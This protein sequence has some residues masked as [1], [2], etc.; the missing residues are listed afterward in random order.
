MVVHA[1][2]PSL[3]PLAAVRATAATAA[4]QGARPWLSRQRSAGCEVRG[5]RPAAL[6]GVA[7]TT[8][9]PPEG[10]DLDTSI[11]SVADVRAELIRMTEE[12]G[13]CST[14]RAPQGSAALLVS[15][16]ER[17]MPRNPYHNFQHIYDV[18]QFLFTL[19]GRSGLVRPNAGTEASAAFLGPLEI[20]AL[21]AGCLCHDLDHP[22]HS[23]V[24]EVA[25][26]GP[27][28]T[29]HTGAS[30]APDTFTLE[31]HHGLVAQRLLCEELGL[32][33]GLEPA[34]AHRFQKLV[35][36]VIEA[37]DL[38]RHQQLYTSF[39]GIATSTP[40]GGSQE[41]QVQLM[42][43][44]MKC[45]DLANTVRPPSCRICWENNAFEE[46]H[47]EGDALV[48]NGLRGLDELPAM[49]D[50]REGKREEASEVFFRSLV[51]PTFTLLEE[52]LRSA[53]GLKPDMATECTVMLRARLALAVQDKEGLAHQRPRPR[54]S[55]LLRAA[56]LLLV[57]LL[58]VL[59]WSPLTMVVPG[60]HGGG[61][62]AGD[63]PAIMFVN[64]T[65]MPPIWSIICF[66]L[67]GFPLI[68][69]WEVH[70][71]AVVKAQPT[72]SEMPAKQNGTLACLSDGVVLV[73]F[74]SGSMDPGIDMTRRRSI[75]C[76]DDAFVDMGVGSGRLSRAFVGKKRRTRRLS[77]PEE[78]MT[79]E[80]WADFSR[81][82]AADRPVF[83]SER[84]STKSSQVGYNAED[85]DDVEDSESLEQVEEQ[86]PCWQGVPSPVRKHLPVLVLCGTMVALSVLNKVL[87][88]LV[89]CSVGRYVHALSS[90]TN[91]AYLFYAWSTVVGKAWLG[92]DTQRGQL[93]R[94][95]RFSAE[96]WRLF[97]SMGICESVAFTLMP[98]GTRG[99]PK[100]LVPVIAQSTL[101]MS[102]VLNALFFRK[103]YSTMQMLGV[104]LIVTGIVL[105]T[106]AD[107]AMATDKVS[108]PLANLVCPLCV[109]TLSYFFLVVSLILKD[110]T[111]LVSA[112]E[113]EQMD[114]FL[115][116]GL[117]GVG[118]ALALL[119]QWPMNFAVLTELSVG[120]YFQAAID[121]FTDS[122]GLMPMLIFLYWAGNILYRLATLTAMRQLSSL[123]TLL[124][125]VL[126]VPLSSLV[127]CLPLGL[128]LIGPPDQLSLL[129]VFGTLVVCFG[130]LTF[131]SN[132]RCCRK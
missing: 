111:F 33:R 101:P 60:A 105:A 43:W 66:V 9:P 45:A 40:D 8:P 39:Q 4:Q 37:T 16:V 12:L 51:L 117:S 88:R 96:R 124:A 90:S 21:W 65:W 81:L 84:A 38:G 14:L 48:A 13:V 116:E 92:T 102:M 77:N 1:R 55:S 27:L 113:G 123:S 6:A 3:R 114:I 30:A 73:E 35:A 58:L 22:G 79:S 49:N 23:C 75:G 63:V 82:Q 24:L 89:L 109:A 64:A 28:H 127:F 104:G 15:E 103:R 99:L 120:E 32:A 11:A 107:P 17:H 78:A 7:V 10:L 52:Y 95:L 26:D 132:A 128:P 76:P 69:L 100:A 130:L 71:T 129:L 59:R 108:Q 47:L 106:A 115:L 86:Q 126:T 46:F 97:A 5:V 72:P 19:L 94:M 93:R 83:L 18:A 50:R 44:L 42:K 110:V 70:H 41:Q 56:A 80:V 61:P 74:V 118:Q 112:Q 29:A 67:L 36:E 34:E 53:H 125:N 131:N 25:L 68:T 31:R 122:K 121:A 119:L 85:I 20:A 62:A 57:P 91:L 2:L 87:F 98:I 54:S